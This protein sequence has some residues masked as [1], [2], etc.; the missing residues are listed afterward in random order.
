MSYHYCFQNGQITI[1][2]VI[3][4]FIFCFSLRDGNT[5]NMTSMF[6]LLH[7]VASVVSISRTITCTFYSFINQGGGGGFPPKESQI[8]RSV[9]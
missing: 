7:A 4:K 5:V 3:T 9:S 1:D 6:F 2:I 8:P